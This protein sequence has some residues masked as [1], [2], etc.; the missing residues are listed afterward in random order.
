[1]PTHDL[2]LVVI[3]NGEAWRSAEWRMR[4][5]ANQSFGFDFIPEEPSAID[6]LTMSE[7]PDPIDRWASREKVLSS[8]CQCVLQWQR[9]SHFRS[10]T[11]INKFNS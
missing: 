2:Y 11:L 7:S 8:F 4:L 1:M 5:I 3:Q 6:T 9:F 10:P